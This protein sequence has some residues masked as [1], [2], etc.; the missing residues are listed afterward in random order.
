MTAIFEREL[1]S[2]FNGVTGYIFGG[3]ILLFTGIYTMAINLSN[4]YSNFEYALS[5]MSFVFLIAIPVLTM[6]VIAEDRRQKTD[7]LLYALPKS[8]TK[9]V[10]GKYLA[11][12]TVLAV[13]LAIMCVYPLILSLFGVVN[14]ASAYS[15]ILAFFLLGA[16][17]AAMG[18]FV[19]ALTENQIVAAVLCFIIVL[20]NYFIS[21]LASFVSATAM[22]SVIALSVAAL[23]VG[24]IFWLL[25]KNIMA[26]IALFAICEGALILFYVR[27]PELLEG[28]FPSVM[29]KLSVFDRFYTFVYGVFDMTAIVY[30]L[31]V[32]GVFIFLTVQAMEK[33]EV[34]INEKT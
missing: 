6:R 7:Q 23:A 15:A 11:M 22:S 2:Y 8:M 30:F 29:E 14:F 19:S 20:I 31:T 33:K 9:I 34:F 12:V 13:P 32:I 4:T 1:R 3:F 25:T 24:A 21:S 5:N 27:S 10:L 28:L 26:G 18:M 17:L 16:T